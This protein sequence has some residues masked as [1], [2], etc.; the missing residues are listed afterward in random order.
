MASQA[1]PMSFHAISM[2][3]LLQSYCRS[4]PILLASYSSPTRILLQPYLKS[5]SKK[6]QNPA[7]NSESSGCAKREEKIGR[8]PPRNATFIF[9]PIFLSILPRNEERKIGE[10]NLLAHSPL[11]AHDS[12]LMPHKT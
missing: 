11:K 3:F 10:T 12:N 4:T 2:R 8:T 5:C 6:C 1:I 9:L 7:E